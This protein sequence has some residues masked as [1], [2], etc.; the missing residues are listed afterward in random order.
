[1]DLVIEE[2][3]RRIDHYRN[4]KGNR[5]EEDIYEPIYGCDRDGNVVYFDADGCRVHESSPAE[6]A[7]MAIGP[8][9]PILIGDWHPSFFSGRRSCRSRRDSQ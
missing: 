2:L 6:I 3:D 5:V 8:D 1:M 9:N 4:S 7:D